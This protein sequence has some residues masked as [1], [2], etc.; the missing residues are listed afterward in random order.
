M[1]NENCSSV[2]RYSI[3]IFFICAFAILTLRP[4]Q[5]F[6]QSGTLVVFANGQSIDQ[7]INN[8]VVNGI[9][10]HSIYKLVS[11]DTVY[12]LSNTINC[13]SN[14]SIIGVPD[15]ATG[16]LPCIEANLLP[17]SSI[18]GIFFSLTGQGTKAIFKNLYL[19]G[20]APNNV[21]N[22]GGG[23][24]IEISADSLSLIIDHCVFDNMCQF[25]ISYR[26][27]W[28]KFY[29]TNSEFRNG[30]FSPSSYY[31]PELLRGENYS[32]NWSSDTIIIK[33]NTMIGIAM[34]AVVPNRLTNYFEFSH[35]N[36][37]LT[38]K[39]PLWVM[40]GTN[41]KIDNNIFYNTYS[42]GESKVEF[43]GGWDDYVVQRMPSIIELDTLD[44]LTAAAF[45]GHA[46]NSPSDY[47]E[48]EA[49]RKIEVMN[50]V[51]F[52]SAGLTSF[53]K[54][55]NDTASV[56]SFYTP[57]F[58]NSET[59]AMFNNKTLWP[60]LIENGNMN[61]DPVF[62]STFEKVLNP[63]SATGY[64]DGLLAF[65]KAIRS[66]TG[67][68]EY[69]AYQKTVVGASIDWA[70]IWPLPESNDLVYSN[71]LLKNGATDGTAIGDTNYSGSNII[72]KP[73][74]SFSQWKIQIKAST[75]LLIDS[76]SFAGVNNSATDGFD[77]TFDVPKPPVPP[78][79]Y[80]YVFF[81]HPEWNSIV[82]PNFQSDI[83]QNSD[84][85]YN[86]KVWSFAVTTDQHNQTMSINLLLD[87]AIPWEY[88]VLLVDMKTDSTIDLRTVNNYTYNCGSDSMRMFQLIV[89][90][91]YSISHNYS[92]GW[93]IMGVP[94]M[95]TLPLESV[96][97]QSSVYYLYGYS[98]N[99]GYFDANNINIGQGCWIGNL[100]GVTANING[101]QNKDSV[102]VPLTPG[103]NMIA[104]PY[105]VP[106]Y[107]KNLM[108]IN[109]GNITVSIDSAVS[110]NWVSPA[111]YSYLP[112]TGNYFAVDTLAPW[113][114]Y[115]FAAVDSS[116]NLIF[117]LPSITQNVLSSAHQLQ[118]ANNIKINKDATTS[119][120]SMKLTLHA[121]KLSDQLGEFGINANA[122][123]GFDAKFD[124]PHPPNPPSSEFLSLAFLHPE[125]STVIGPNFSTDIK[126]TTQSSIWKLIA[127]TSGN[128]TEAE[129]KWDSTTVP[130]GITLMLIDLGNT[131]T[132]VN[133]SMTGTY[134][135]II[136][137][138][139]SL[140]ITSSITGISQQ[141]V[142]IPTVYAL[143][144]NY[145]NPFNPT[146]I[147]KYSVPKAGLVTIK[148]FDVL[149]RE[150]S[151]LVNQEKMPGNYNAE[152]DAGSLAS[153]IYFYRMKAGNFVDTKKLV[154]LK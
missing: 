154:L 102:V 90:G 45:L 147:I 63:G 56:D 54:T 94:L 48:A 25:D 151:T 23:Q 98:T 72:V 142:L 141:P 22:Y 134:R 88:P 50:N 77:T 107:S 124:L 75:N 9:Q 109:N 32:G 113:N 61:V 118:A 149:G 123:T 145:P 101:V 148:V 105:Y 85:T 81:P 52:W 133:M 49:A 68:T 30:M 4:V 139:D 79:N 38:T 84:L 60:G 62:G 19:L 87:N 152:F 53:W 128:N 35:N 16:R 83:R 122:K 57:Q 103:F 42:T 80:V 26:S 111:L 114:G 6:A 71:V 78:N 7:I 144:Q 76:T 132:Q 67:T 40:R 138:T 112:S 10:I 21:T 3:S 34:S 8:D 36:V 108:F 106:S 31:I 93:N 100:S 136:N 20:I 127:T 121:G 46:I 143:S 66:Q 74:L 104:L 115:W 24:G 82:G 120:W 29:I 91:P 43:N 97:G 65:I 59:A 12:L 117:E 58:M 28:N 146:T 13:Q 86:N 95:N 110:L 130:Q 64:G 69:Y 5:I 55:W 37:M 92:P 33:N 70:P 150:V 27:N 14:I 99:S 135:F 137:N 89:G 140:Q 116:L 2:I 119:N 126:P 17:N 153:G 18:P 125:W 129:L 131:K 73:P 51:Y 44:T 11:T 1:E 41:M 96:F 15:A 47:A 39:G